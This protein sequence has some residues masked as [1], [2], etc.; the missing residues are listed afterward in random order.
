MAILQSGLLILFMASYAIPNN[1][2]SFSKKFISGEA[3]FGFWNVLGKGV[4]FIN[5]FFIISSLSLYEY[6]VFQLLL[7]GY[8]IFSDLLSTGGGVVGNDI[9]RFIGEG[10]E[11]KAKKLFFEYNKF[12]IIFGILLWA[13]FFFGAPLLSFRYG[14]DF[15]D[16]IRILSFLFLIEVFLS[17][18]KSLLEMRLYFKE[19]AGRSTIGKIIQLVILSYFFFFAHIGTRE[20]LLSMVAALFLSTMT[21]L[22]M[23]RE[24]YKPWK[25]IGS[26]ERSVLYSI[27]RAHGKWDIFRKFLSDATNK[28]KPWLI[29]LFISTEAVAVFSVAVS[30][31][32][33]FKTFLPTNTLATLVPRTLHEEARMKMIF[34]FGVK[35]LVWL[36]IL[37]MIFG[38]IITPMAIYLLFNQYLVALPFAFILMFLL[39]IQSLWRMVDIYLVALREQKF[40]FMRTGLRSLLSLILLLILLPLFGLWGM[41]IYELLLP[42]VIAYMSYRYLIK[43]KP[44]LRFSPISLF[45]FTNEDRNM[46]K[47]LYI[48]FMD[49]FSVKFKTLK[50]LI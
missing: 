20:V 15:L 41:V 12:R 45:R 22:P 47:S 21:L 7:A 11:E 26:L 14:P 5:T 50:E 27:F 42:I 1:N 4:G 31:V 37:L 24:A 9:I 32:N 49:L 39:P 8:N 30:I 40:F 25:R 6:G 28:I 16:L 3:Y 48:N 13:T 33:V 23:A 29:K 36:G 10:K 34:S 38:W 17:I 44:Q 19:A 35:Y 2:F 46:I 43:I 18:S